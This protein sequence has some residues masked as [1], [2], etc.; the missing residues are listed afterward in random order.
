MKNG[1]NWSKF[2]PELE[3]KFTVFI[4]RFLDPSLSVL[5]KL[6]FILFHKWTKSFTFTWILQLLSHH[7]CSQWPR[8]IVSFCCKK[9]SAYFRWTL[10]QN[11]HSTMPRKIHINRC[12]CYKTFL[13]RIKAHLHISTI[14]HWACRFT[15]QT[16]NVYFLKWPS[17]IRSRGLKSDV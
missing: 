9:A 4:K 7:Q 8:L 5:T 6:C 1:L 10:S 15:K 16:K 14:L 17:L 12:Q 11:F 13:L 2:C 3:Q